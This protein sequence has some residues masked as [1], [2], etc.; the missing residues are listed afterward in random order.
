MA[1]NRYKNWS[2]TICKIEKLKNCVLLT[3]GMDSLKDSS[4]G[5]VSDSLEQ[6]MVNEENA[7]CCLFLQIW[8]LYQF[9]LGFVPLWLQTLCTKLIMWF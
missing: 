9:K 7:Q 3:S 8:T 2:T 6:T 1:S 5:L 4:K